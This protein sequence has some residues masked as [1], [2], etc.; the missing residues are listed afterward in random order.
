[1][2]G[3]S[4]W[5][6][7]V[8]V[9]ALAGCAVGPQDEARSIEVNVDAGLVDGP[10]A[11]ASAEEE[12]V[13]ASVYLVRD[14]RLIHVT[15]AVAGTAPDLESVVAEAAAGPTSAEARAGIWNAIPAPSSVQGTRLNG[16]VAEVDLSP[17]FAAIGG[18]DEI[19]AIAQLVLSATSL[20]E[21][22][23][24]TFSLNGAETDVPRADGALVSRPLTTEDYREL[25]EP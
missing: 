10:A 9:V 2:K 17:D 20:S 8:G 6:V 25:V 19:L 23:A 12:S 18:R 21:V 5:L 15:R 22:D 24:V 14:N 13:A 16:S 4:G 1:M 7:L 11:D 3:A